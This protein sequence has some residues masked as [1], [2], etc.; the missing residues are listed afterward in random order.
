MKMNRIAFYP[1]IDITDKKQKCSNKYV[2]NV[3]KIL[4]ENNEVVPYYHMAQGINRLWEYNCIFLNWYERELTWVDKLGLILAKV[5]GKKI[6][7]TFHNRMNHDSKNVKLDQA[8]IRFLVRISSSI[9]VLSKNSIP[10]LYAM[11]RQRYKV[12]KNII[13]VPHVNYVENYLP[14]KQEDAQELGLKDFT[15]LYFGQVRPYKNLEV[16]IEAYNNID[17]GISRLVIA[18]KPLDAKYARR[19]KK[20]CGD[21]EKIELDF[22]FIDDEEVYD[23]M[24]RAD[25]VVLPYDKK[26]SMNSGAMIAAFS[27]K[28]PVIVPDIA[29]AR[30]YKNSSYVYRYQYKIKQQHVEKL[31]EAMMQA[32]VNGKEKNRILG[33]QAYEEV[34]RDNSAEVVG[35]CLE[36]I[37]ERK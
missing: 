25:V 30:D 19:I 29:M 23:Y 26:S 21:N 3:E 6:I 33:L 37:W 1:Y 18:G 4:L 31:A 22:R 20:L 15:F 7:W 13:Y 11:T 14:L 16:L 10:Y 36:K 24:S 32:Y 8:N 34:K 9:V 28:K 17:T 35:K 27:C 12:K 5:L 2:Y